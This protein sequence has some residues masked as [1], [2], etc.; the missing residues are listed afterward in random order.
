M[1]LRGRIAL[2]TGASSGIGY[3]AAFRLAEAGADVALG[4]AHK[5][6]AAR[7]LAEHIH[8]MGRRALPVR[9]NLGVPAQIHTLVDATETG[10][11]PIDILVSN[12]GMGTRKRLEELTLEE[13]DQ[14]MRVNLRAAFVLAQR[15]T[16]GMRERGWGRVIFVS[17]VA[18]FTGGIVGPHY[19]ASKAGLLGLMH[20]LSASLAPHGVTVNAVAPALIADTG[21]LPGGPQGEQELVPRI[22]VGRL[23]KPE[24]V[25]E[26]MLML[27]ANSYLT[28]QTLLIDGGMYPH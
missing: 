28:N 9:A 26:V 14:T 3:V 1:D 11:G 5:E 10:L 24:D 12:A 2:I 22:P 21:M 17:S 25:V 4:Y 19:A 6:Q 7:T 18:A 23:G 20:S 15:I 27:V 8:Q 16:P 13:W